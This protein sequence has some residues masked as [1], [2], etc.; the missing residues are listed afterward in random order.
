MQHF[1]TDIE[2]LEC[3]TFPHFFRAMGNGQANYGVMAI[4]N[5]VVG[6]ILSNYGLLKESVLTIIGEVY[7]RIEHHLMGL[8]GQSLQDIKDVESHR[9]ALLQC[10]HFLDKN[11]E[12]QV[13]YGSD[14]ALIARQIA[15]DNKNGLAA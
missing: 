12:I 8:Q 7:L 6:T 13:L 10:S 3:E 5:S 14:T 2:V 4:E 15:S 1:G 9:M 11:P